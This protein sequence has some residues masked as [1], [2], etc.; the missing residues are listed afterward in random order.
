MKEK[1]NL[2]IGVA[3]GYDF[4]QMRPFMDSLKRI[5]FNG[6]VIIAGDD[7]LVIP[8]D[9]TRF[10][11]VEV[12]NEK[13]LRR[14][15]VL[16]GTNKFLSSPYVRNVAKQALFKISKHNEGLFLNLFIHIYHIVNA[17]I[18]FYYKYLKYN[19][20]EN[21]FIT[22]IRDVV[23][24]SDPFVGFSGGC[25]VFQE[26]EN[27]NIK[28]DKWSSSW[29]REGYGE[30]VLNAIGDKE[31][32]CAGT[33]LSDYESAVSLLKNMLIECLHWK[34]RMNIYGPDMGVLLYLIHTNGVSNLIKRKNGDI[35]LTVSPDTYDVIEIKN[36]LIEYKKIQPA[37]VHQYDR[38][39]SLATF[40]NGL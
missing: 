28:S 3:Y 10:L 35:V 33:I 5:N 24:Q 2:I 21:V 30:K 37:V 23:F 16:R 27:T 15:I 22:D 39:A 9:Y 25:N 32:Y 14:S 7:N 19:K 17:R 12:I 29:I 36:E 20:F 38:I 1:K 6:V 4:E 40:F 8:V 26:N 18:A 11:N 34:G 31:I 13:G